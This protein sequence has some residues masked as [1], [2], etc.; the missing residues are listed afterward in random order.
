MIFIKIC[1]T[2]AREYIF[3]QKTQNPQCNLY[4]RQQS[5]WVSVRKA[6]A[7]EVSK[8]SEQAKWASGVNEW[9]ERVEWASGVSEWSHPH[10]STIRIN[11]KLA[12]SHD[13]NKTI[14]PYSTLSLY[15]LT[16]QTCK[17]W[18]A[19]GDRVSLSASISPLHNEWIVNTKYEFKCG[20]HNW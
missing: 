8:R 6:P 1:Q 15:R 16:N 20:T 19:I 13:V 5:E 2:S 17:V 3:S 14:F 9:S 18:T 11:A 7:S 10:D 4:E 12:I